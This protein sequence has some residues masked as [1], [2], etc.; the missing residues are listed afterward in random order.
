[1]STRLSTVTTVV[2]T[3]TAIALAAST[4][5]RVGTAA[6]VERIMPVVYSPVIRSAP[7]TAMVII[8]S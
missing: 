6:R 8:P 2:A 4:G 7:S 1:V 5:R 3:E